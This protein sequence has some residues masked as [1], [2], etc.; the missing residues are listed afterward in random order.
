MGERVVVA[1]QIIDTLT[2]LV[3]LDKGVP[4]EITAFRVQPGNPSQVLPLDEFAQRHL[5]FSVSF[6]GPAG[7]RALTFPTDFTFDNGSIGLMRTL[8]KG[9]T[10]SDVQ[11]TFGLDAVN[12]AMFPTAFKMRFESSD[13][14]VDPALGINMTVLA[15]RV[16]GTV[17]MQFDANQTIQPI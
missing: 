6:A 16:T 2:G 14:S 12:P 8:L 11:L 5:M 4:G 9:A 13:L 10:L 1:R 7:V 3:V 17:K 15:D